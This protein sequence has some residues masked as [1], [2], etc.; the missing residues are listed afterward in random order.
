M[1]TFAAENS[2]RN[3]LDNRKTFVNAWIASQLLR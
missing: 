1:R 3:C 2:R